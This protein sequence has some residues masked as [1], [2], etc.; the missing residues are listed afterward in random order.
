[1]ADISEYMRRAIAVA[2]T[3][4]GQTSPNPNVGCVL[5]K[6]NTV[7]AEGVYRGEGTPHAELAAL[8]AAGEAARGAT[9]YVTLEP[10]SHR[11]SSATG[12][13]RVP[14][15]DA[16]IA[17]GV[18]RVVFA[19]V[20]PDPRTDGRGAQALREAGVAVEQGD[21]EAE[22]TKLHEAFLKHRRTGLPF[23]VVKYAATLDGRLSAG[24]GDSRWVSGP[25]TLAW[26][27]RE[28]L[29][30]DAIIVGSQNVLADDPQLTARPGGV[31]ADHPL[32]RMV[33]D[34]TGRISPAARVLD[35]AA[36][37]LIVTTERS[38]DAWRQAIHATGHELLVL[39]PDEHGRV[40]LV[41][42]LQELGRR[43]VLTLQVE[44]GGVLHGSFFDQRL[45]DKATIVIAPKIVGAV[46]AAQAVSGAGAQY[47]RD[48]VTF[49]DLTVERL[50]DDVLFTGYPVWPEVSP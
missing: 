8:Q 4:A 6:E 44:G 30:L 41:P 23:V 14:C 9:A 34:S 26:A 2:E 16:L 31:Q 49:R 20:D 38:P 24:S 13:P 32:L 17:A 1:M 11:V 46:T 18:S 39:P 27:H 10:C 48:A 28:R 21:G 47:M 15:C 45:V 36:K 25:E 40:P 37:T 33:A 3:M 43:G 29:K 19:L 7:I 22:A 50:G 5:V 35:G 42:L 12:L